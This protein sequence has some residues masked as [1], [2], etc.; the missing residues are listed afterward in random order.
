MHP[1]RRARL[2]VVQPGAAQQVVRPSAIGGGGE[3]A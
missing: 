3:A 1:L 2:R